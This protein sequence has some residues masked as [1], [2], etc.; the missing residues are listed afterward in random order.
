MISSQNERT[1]GKAGSSKINKDKQDGEEGMVGVK[2]REY[3]ANL[4]FE[5]PLR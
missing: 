5:C 2:T 4:L 3:W 1:L